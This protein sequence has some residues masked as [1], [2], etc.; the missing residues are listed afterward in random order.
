MSKRSAIN[1]LILSRHRV[2]DLVKEERRKH[3]GRDIVS[4]EVLT[5]GNVETAIADREAIAAVMEAGGDEEAARKIRTPPPDCSLTSVLI[6]V[7]SEREEVSVFHEC[8][9]MPR[10]AID[11]E[12]K[13][14]CDEASR[15]FGERN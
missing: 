8:P 13:V 6:D 10:S 9:G 11:P 15:R 14:Q 3:P 12:I 7:Q 1:A 2:I 5:P 4:V